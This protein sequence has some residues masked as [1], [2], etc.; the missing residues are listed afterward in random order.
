MLRLLL[1]DENFN[2][3]IVHGLEL[4]LPSLDFLI[5]QEMPRNRTGSSSR[6]T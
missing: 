4:R 3:R 2:H 1:F 5:A 6:T